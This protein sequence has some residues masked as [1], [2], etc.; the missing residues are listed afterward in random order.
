[1]IPQMIGETIFRLKS[2]S[3]TSN[4]VARSIESGD[5]R[6]GTAILADF[7]TDG[8][9]QRNAAWQSA[10][11][12]NLTFS[13]GAELINIDPRAYFKVTQCISVAL[14]RYL[15]ERLSD[16]VH[17]KWPNDMICNGKKLAGILVESKGGQN[18]YVICGIGLNVNQMD[19]GELEKAGSLHQLTGLKYDLNSEVGNLLIC[20][21]EE[22]G[23]LFQGDFR[24]LRDDYKSRL[25]GFNAKVAFQEGD[26]IYE[27]ILRDVSE[28]GQLVIEKDDQTREFQ[29]K[30][31][32]LIY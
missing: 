4:Y 9:G 17:I 27:G 5:Y 31:V 15:S 25:F 10:R 20:L 12:Q 3:S 1:M 23:K 7:Q 26:Q 30:A 22:W 16:Q 6:W 11:G 18:P 24:S 14:H 29:P 28:E 8:R 21:N 2:V 32:Q 13:F 19:F